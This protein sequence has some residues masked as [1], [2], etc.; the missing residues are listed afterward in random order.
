MDPN[1]PTSHSIPGVRVYRDVIGPIIKPLFVSAAK[2]VTGLAGG[3]Y[4]TAT[5]PVGADLVQAAGEKGAI[6]K[7]PVELRPYAEHVDELSQ[8]DWCAIALERGNEMTVEFRVPE[9]NLRILIH[10]SPRKYEPGVLEV[11][12]DDGRL[13]KRFD[14][15]QGADKKAG[16]ATTQSQPTSSR[17]R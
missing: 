8:A 4:R 11:W 12:S 2:R 15:K 5:Q 3:V 10:G 17:R 1:L 6:L 9:E 16:E 13:L 14:P 7:V